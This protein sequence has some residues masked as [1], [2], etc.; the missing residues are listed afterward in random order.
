[1]SENKLTEE[2]RSRV[3]DA[4]AQR[5]SDLDIDW[6]DVP[7][8]G[9]PSTAKVREFVRGRSHVLSAGK[10]RE[11]EHALDWMYG[12]IGDILDG[13]APTPITPEGKHRERPGP[14]GT[15]IQVDLTAIPGDALLEELRRRMR[16]DLDYLGS[17]PVRRWTGLLELVETKGDEDGVEVET[18]PDAPSQGGQAEEDVLGGPLLDTFPG[19]G[20][21]AKRRGRL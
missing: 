13:L 2:Q 10:R 14:G 16:S 5:V 17:K 21:E 11:L 6:K 18:E 15:S 4:I 7:A 3:A 8:R 12:S 20:A 1:M 9:G 19:F